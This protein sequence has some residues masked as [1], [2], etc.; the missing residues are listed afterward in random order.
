MLLDQL[1]QTFQ[2]KQPQHIGAGGGPANHEAHDYAER[3]RAR[4]P[5]RLQ[6]LREATGMSRYAFARKAGV[7][8]D[9]AG[10]NEEGE[11]IPTQPPH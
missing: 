8:R 9:M 6:E 2:T 4:L 3:I 7:S 1:N 10:C 11:S 5:C